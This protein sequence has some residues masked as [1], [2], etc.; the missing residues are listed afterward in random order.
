MGKVTEKAIRSDES[1]FWRDWG[2]DGEFMGEV[3]EKAI[4]SDE[5]TKV[6]TNGNYNFLVAHPSI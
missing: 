4:R 5:Y 1:K 2:R 6:A 3:T